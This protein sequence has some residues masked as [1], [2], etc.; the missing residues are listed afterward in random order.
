M[1]SWKIIKGLL[2]TLAI[3]F[4]SL[5]VLIE[6][7]VSFILKARTALNENI[8]LRFDRENDNPTG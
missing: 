1:N 4:L 3:V 8:T 7:G 2:V 6:K 5:C